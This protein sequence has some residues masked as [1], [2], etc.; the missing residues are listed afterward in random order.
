MSTGLHLL[1]D[2]QS[3]EGLLSYKLLISKFICAIVTLHCLPNHILQLSYL[4]LAT[5][6]RLFNHYVHRNLDHRRPTAGMDHML[7]GKGIC[8]V[9]TR[10]DFLKNSSV[11]G[12]NLK[13][14]QSEVIKRVK[15]WTS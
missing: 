7:L 10:S 5:T 13:S 6:L 11:K 8:S 12:P 15:I 2:Q 14:C 4:S 1:C 3:T 9:Q